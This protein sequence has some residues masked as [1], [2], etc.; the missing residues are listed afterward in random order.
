M[1]R[2]VTLMFVFMYLYSQLKDMAAFYYFEEEA[3]HKILYAEAS[4]FV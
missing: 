4:K 1:A 2:Q 3:A